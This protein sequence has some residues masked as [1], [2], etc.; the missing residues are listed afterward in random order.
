MLDRAIRDEMLYGESEES[1]YYK[2]KDD[3]L[4]GSCVLQIQIEN[5]AEYLKWKKYNGGDAR[6]DFMVTYPAVMR[7][8]YTFHTTAD[9]D[10]MTYKIVQLLQ[11]GF[12]V[13]AVNWQLE[14]YKSQ[15]KQPL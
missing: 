10:Q 9:L 12:K 6:W 1:P 15:L 7:R 8:E 14:E 11:M 4:Y 2:P 3:T 5:G 13:R